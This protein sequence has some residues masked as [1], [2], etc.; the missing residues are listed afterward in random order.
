L[1]VIE[2]VNFAIFDVGGQRNERRKWIHCFE[3][4]SA[5]L[6]IVAISA[7]D[8]MLIEDNTTNRLQEAFNLF[9]D[10]INS[11][12][13]EHTSVILF[14]NKF[15]L[16][17]KKV[18]VSNLVDHFP[19]YDGDNSCDDAAE[20]IREGFLELNETTKIVYHHFTCG[21]DTNNMNII[22]NSVRDTILNGYLKNSGLV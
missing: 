10:I 14:L 12:W 2:G 17:E 19:E 9:E 18:L 20:W 16:F 4:V 22:F 1:Y 6:F 3:A 11:A 7:Y 5:I 15:D 13:F 21:T 8:Q